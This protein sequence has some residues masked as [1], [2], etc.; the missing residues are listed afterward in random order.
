MRVYLG[1]GRFTD[2]LLNT[3]GGAGVVE[4]PNLQR[5]LHFICERGFEHHVAAN[6][7]T[8]ASSVHEATTHYLELSEFLPQANQRNGTG[9]ML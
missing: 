4:T 1:E 2:D 7:S 9:V 3:L 5:L 8:V 6:L